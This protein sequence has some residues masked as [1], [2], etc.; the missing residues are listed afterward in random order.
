MKRI[1]VLGFLLHVHFRRSSHLSRNAS[2]DVILNYVFVLGLS[3]LKALQYAL[4][5]TKEN[6]QTH[7][8]RVLP[9]VF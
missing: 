8:S 5:L 1:K 2:L 7:K 3:L 6:K 9:H 4:E